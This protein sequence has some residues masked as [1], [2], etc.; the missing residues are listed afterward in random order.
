MTVPEK[1]A[2][3]K[4]IRRIVSDGFTRAETDLLTSDLDVL[5]DLVREAGPQEKLIRDRIPEIVAEKGESIR[6]RMA[7]VSEYRTLL[8]KKL[9]EEAHEV[10]ADPRSVDE[11]ADVLEV[12]RA[13]ALDQGI[14]LDQVLATAEKKRA[15]RGGF[16]TRTVLVP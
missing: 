4:R 3:L 16:V 2:A 5:D 1:L 9:V 11:L 12:V 10:L 15:E 14:T 6:T 7:N 13:M 8:A